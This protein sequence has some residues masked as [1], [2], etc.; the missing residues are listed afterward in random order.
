MESKHPASEESPAAEIGGTSPNT[1]FNVVFQSLVVLGGLAAFLYLLFFEGE[2]SSPFIIAA[3]GLILLWPLRE[4]KAIRALLLAGGF[5]LGIWTLNRLGGVLAPFAFVFLLAFLLNPL[6]AR[7]H[8]RFKVKRWIT[9]LLLTLAFVGVLVLFALL[10]VPSL[11]G[12][13]EGLATAI[14]NLISGLP[15]WVAETDV[16]N[17]LERTGLIQRDALM[18]QLTTF[19]PNQINSIA[20]RIPSAVSTLTRSVGTL[21]GLLTTIALIPVLLFYVLKDYTLIRESIINLFPRF[22]GS[23]DYLSQTSKVVGNYLRGQLTISAIGAIIVTIPLV[24][25]GVPFALVIGL[26]T[27]LL[28]MIPNLGAIITYLIGGLLMIAFGTVGDFFLVMG[29]LVGQ[30]FLEQSV[31]TPNIMGQSVGLHPVLIIFSLFVFSA[32][33]GF[34]GL[35]IAVPVTALLVQVYKAYRDDFVIDIEPEPSIIVAKTNDV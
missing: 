29:V 31:L 11:V 7:A 20:A 34:I 22:R 17:S 15:Q 14:I 21:F 26:L 10:I 9:S 19:L 24:I 16:L 2:A 27:G 25:F 32:F 23:R 30:S 35:L 13:I 28:N 4:Y 1:A 3:A 18:E 5:V 6:V 8:E 12:Q 33:F